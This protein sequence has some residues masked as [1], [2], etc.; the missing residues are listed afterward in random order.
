MH[1]F[2]FSFLPGVRK[3]SAEDVVPEQLL[4]AKKSSLAGDGEDSPGREK[5]SAKVKKLEPG[6]QA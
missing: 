2:C 5:G 4:L 1:F 3:G 6:G